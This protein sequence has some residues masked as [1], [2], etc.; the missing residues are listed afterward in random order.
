LF[1]NPFQKKLFNNPNQKQEKTTNDYPTEFDT[2]RDKEMLFKL[3]INQKNVEQ[4]FYT[5]AVKKM[6]DDNEIIDEFK[7]KYYIECHAAPPNGKEDDDV[8]IIGPITPQTDDN[9]KVVKYSLYLL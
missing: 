9:I 5:Y 3:E 1:T 2:L 4:R 8:D 7:K 6:S